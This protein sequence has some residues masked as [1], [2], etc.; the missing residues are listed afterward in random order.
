MSGT[1]HPRR[2]SAVPTA[3]ALL[4]DRTRRRRRVHRQLE[5]SALQL[6]QRAQVHRGRVRSRRGAALLNA[7]REEREAPAPATPRAAGQPNAGGLTRV[8]VSR[9][10][11]SSNV[12]P[13][14]RADR[15]TSL[16]RPPYAALANACSDGRRSDVLRTL[17]AS[18]WSTTRTTALRPER[19]V[20]LAAV[21]A[22]RRSG[23]RR[24]RVA[25]SISAIGVP[26]PLL[27]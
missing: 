16:R 1:L 12:S 23:A 25:T 5:E 4:H 7:A 24:D 18:V 10:A 13:A 19:T 8:A 6:T 21:A 27:S 14:A 15:C 9:P 2:A 11:A 20:T 22:H 3:A 17:G 26:H